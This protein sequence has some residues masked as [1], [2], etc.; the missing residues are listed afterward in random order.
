MGT[1]L[2]TERLT[3]VVAGDRIVDGVSI[4]VSEGDVLA[5]LGPSGSGK[6]SLLRLLNRLDEPTEGTVFLD[7]T[8]YRDLPPREVRRRI[9]IVPQSPALRDG[10]VFENVTIGP[11]LR[12]E[13]VGRETAEELLARMNLDGYADRDVSDL[14]GGEAQR[15]AIART[16]ITEPEV[17]LLDEPTSSLDSA[18]EAKVETLLEGLI[19]ETDLTTVLVTH[20]DSQ[21]RRLA[22][23]VAMLEDGRVE[24]VGPVSEVMA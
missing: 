11:R 8:D 15:V 9:G 4:S 23:R 20:D 12:G 24:S 18:S 13:T 19:H 2:E 22:D 21:A 16:L 3:R 17:L 14:S 7:G 1:K 6:S 5:V 10:T